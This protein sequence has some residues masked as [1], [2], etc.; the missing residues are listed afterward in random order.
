MNDLSEHIP[1]VVH[2]PVLPP[3][4]FG[5]LFGTGFYIFVIAQHKCPD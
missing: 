4:E 1:S 5:T 3:T 2:V